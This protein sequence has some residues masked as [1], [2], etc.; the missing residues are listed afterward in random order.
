MKD[1]TI[2]E[3]IHVTHQQSDIRYGTSSGIQCSCM[4]LWRVNSLDIV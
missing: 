1:C 3:V 2:I 4:A